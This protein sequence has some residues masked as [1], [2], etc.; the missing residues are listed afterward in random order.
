ML[1]L[2]RKTNQVILIGRDIELRVLYSD[3]SYVKIGI[4][5]PKAIPILREELYRKILQKEEK[6]K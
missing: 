6:Q 5:A 3:S 1:I 4:N 2:T